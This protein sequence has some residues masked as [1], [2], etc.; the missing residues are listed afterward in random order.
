M[1]IVISMAMKAK[2]MSRAHHKSRNA[3]RRQN[4]A[5]GIQEKRNL[6]NMAKIAK[7]QIQKGAQR[8]KTQTCQDNKYPFVFIGRNSARPNAMRG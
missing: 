1:I 4:H 5:D 8:R 3:L 6:I 7:T 2:A